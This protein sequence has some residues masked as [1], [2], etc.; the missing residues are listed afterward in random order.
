LQGL[1][2]E[3]LAQL[4]SRGSIDYPEIPDLGPLPASSPTPEHSELE[5]ASEED[6]DS[7]SDD[8]EQEDEPDG[9][10]EDEYSEKG[11]GAASSEGAGRRATR[12]SRTAKDGSPQES[13]EQKG[14][15][16]SSEAT[17]KPN[18]VPKKRK[19]G[20]P[21]KIDTPEEARIRTV[22]RAIRKVKDED[23]RQLFLEFERL[24]DPAQ[25]P[26]YYT[27]IEKPIALN[28]ITVAQFGFILLI[29]EKD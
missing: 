8:S 13:V 3:E 20:R 17:P 11:K 15:T 9:E 12:K 18:A 29:L 22:L 19:R 1:L 6:D 24:P 14:T 16:S 2:A 5:S 23:G 28:T 25:Y 7:D 27:E 10:D 26:D 4:H 21:P